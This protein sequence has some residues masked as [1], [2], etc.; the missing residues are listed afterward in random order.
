MTERESE[1]K[2][3]L[4]TNNEFADWSK[5]EFRQFINASEKYGRTDLEQIA[6]DVETKTYDE[7]NVIRI[8]V[9]T[10]ATIDTIFDI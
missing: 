1:E 10:W 2:V 8:T 4:L 7:V 9:N 5:R 3:R 6:R